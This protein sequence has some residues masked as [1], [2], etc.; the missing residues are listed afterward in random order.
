MET[1]EHVRY[2]VTV[3]GAE[4][5]KTLLIQVPDAE[6]WWIADGTILDVDE[7]GTAVLQAGNAALR[8]DGDRLKEIAALAQAWYGVQRA[9]LN[10]R[11]LGIETIPKVGSYVTST[12]TGNYSESI[13]SA[14]STIVYDLRRVRTTIVTNY[15][16]LDFAGFGR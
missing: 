14:V 15:E 11:I 7:D 1:D 2:A 16:E 6:G 12:L 5:T 9:T 10:V 8:N 4:S 3:P 13:N